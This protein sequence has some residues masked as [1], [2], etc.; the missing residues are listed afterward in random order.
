MSEDRRKRQQERESHGQPWTPPK[1]SLKAVVIVG[2]LALVA[3]AIFI[4][5]YRENT[6]LDAFAKCLGTKQAKMYGAFWCPHCA[7][8]KELFGGSFKHAPYIECG[9]TGQQG[10][11]QVCKDAGIQRFPTWIF[12][13]GTRTEGKK[14]L[15]YLSDQTGCSLP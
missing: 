9:I 14:S 12:A 1:P 4:G 13:N 8:Q 11:Q 10:I 2:I 7:E 15:E 5:W 6:H 3:I